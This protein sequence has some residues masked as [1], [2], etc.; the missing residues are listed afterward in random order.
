MTEPSR[1]TM[2]L[3]VIVHEQT[4]RH[5]GRGRKWLVAMSD[6]PRAIALNTAADI[7]D[8]STQVGQAL[9]GPLTTTSAPLQSSTVPALQRQPHMQGGGRVQRQRQQYEKQV[10]QYQRRM[11]QH[12]PQM[13]ES[14][15]S[16]RAWKFDESNHRWRRRDPISGEWIWA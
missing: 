6:P 13:P 14:Q 1:A 11:Q 12:R 10:R 9:A 15:Q 16:Q 2:A 8:P 4:N 7:L 3:L 5:N